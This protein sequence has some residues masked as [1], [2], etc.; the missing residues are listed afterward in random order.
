MRQEPSERLAAPSRAAWIV[1]GGA[2]FLWIG[3]EDQGPRRPLLLAGGLA[4]ALGLTT[5]RRWRRWRRG[6]TRGTD[7]HEPSWIRAVD[8]RVVW[9]AMSTL[10]GLVAGAL[11]GPG[12]AVLMLIKTSLH[13]HATPEFLP[14]DLAEVLIRTPAWMLAGLCAGAALGLTLLALDGEPLEDS[15][16]TPARYNRWAGGEGEDG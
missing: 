11:V 9:L 5:L 2:W 12:A 15:R 7:P 3:V 4:M 8:G 13:S 10:T 1:A 16:S 6:E 14:A